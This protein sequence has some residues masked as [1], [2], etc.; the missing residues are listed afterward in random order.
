MPPHRLQIGKQARLHIQEAQENYER[1][2]RLLHSP[3]D[4]GWALVSLFYSA[5]HLVQAHAIAKCPTLHPPSPVPMDHYTRS[6]YVIDHLGRLDN[7]YS[8]LRD[9]SE[10]VRYSLWKPDINEVKRYHDIEFSRVRE[11]LR[12]LGISWN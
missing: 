10:D 6:R 11:H 7:H 3:P 4:A 2:E 1:Y 12:H 5:V 9:A 8:R